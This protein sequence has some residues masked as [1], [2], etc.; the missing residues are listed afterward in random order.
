MKHRDEKGFTFMEILIVVVIISLLVAIVGPRLIGQTY[1]AKKAATMQ[2]IGNY[3]TALYP[4]TDQGL[5]ALVEKPTTGREPKNYREKGYLEKRDIPKDPWKSPYIYIS[6]GLHGDYDIFSYG[7]DG[8]EGGEG[9]DADITSW[10][11]E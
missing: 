10:E 3:E 5:E 6:P 11:V 8:E 2:Q 7:A 9:E 4:S 1:K